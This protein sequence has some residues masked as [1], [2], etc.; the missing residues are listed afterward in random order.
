MP[1]KCP[2][3]RVQVEAHKGS[4]RELALGQ[5]AAI[6]AWRHPEDQS[7]MRK[8]GLAVYS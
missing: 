2:S 8:V 7:G 6:H 5:Q 3:A 4:G 1:Q